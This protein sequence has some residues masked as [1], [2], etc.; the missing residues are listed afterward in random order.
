MA[1]RKDCAVVGV[2]G[3]FLLNVKD[4]GLEGLRPKYPPY[5]CRLV[6]S[7][8]PQALP[9]TRKSRAQP[10]A[11]AGFT[12]A[13]QKEVHL[14]A[15]SEEANSKWIGINAPIGIGMMQQEYAPFRRPFEPTNRGATQ[16]LCTLK[17]F[18]RRHGC[19]AWPL[20][21]LAA[22]VVVD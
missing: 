6:Q 10:R 19:A 9:R 20:P 11:K 5:G 7:Q 21:G 1:T 22:L 2:G 17:S 8:G 3:A 18:T 15:L 12:V 13:Q 14:Q 4:E 16:F